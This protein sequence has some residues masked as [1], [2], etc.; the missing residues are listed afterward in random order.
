MPEEAVRALLD[1]H[2]CKVSG[3]AYR[4]TDEGRCFEYRMTIRTNDARNFSRLATSLAA[5]PSVRE[6][7]VSPSGD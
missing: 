4:L 7:H 3:L 5:L 6:F 1:R 2:G